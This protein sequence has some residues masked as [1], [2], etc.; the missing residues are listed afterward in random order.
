MSFNLS[1]CSVQSPKAAGRTRTATRLNRKRKHRMV[2]G[3][4]TWRKA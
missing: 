2:K 3:V 1:V 4:K